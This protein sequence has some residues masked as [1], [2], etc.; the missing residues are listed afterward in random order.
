MARRRATPSPADELELPSAEELERLKLSPEVAW[1][2]VSRGIP[3]PDCP[4]AIKTPEPG[5]TCPGARFD[6]D[7]VDKVL[8]SFGLLRHTKGKWAGTP[9]QPDPWQVAYV[10]APVFG[11]V[12]FDE[13]VSRWV[14]VIRELYVDIPRKN[15]KSTTLGGIAI[16]MTAAD[17]EHGAEVI[18]AATTAEQAGFVFAPIKAMCD[19]APALKGHLK[20]YS[21]RIVHPRS[22]SYFQAISSV[23]DA[24]HGANIH[25]AV[26]D[27]LH[28]HKSA[29]LVETLETGTGSRDQPLVATITTADDGKPNTIYA[30]KR[31]RI[32]QLARQALTDPTTYGV[33]WAAAKD[34]DPFVEETWRKANPGFGISP[35]RSYLAKEA[36]KAKDSPA[37]LAKF[38][39][40]HLGI[41]TKQETKY[42]RLED[43]DASAGMVDELKLKG[44]ACHGGLD[45]ASVNDVTALC[46]DFPGENDQHELLWRFWLPEARIDDMNKRTAGAAAVWVR[47]GRLQLTPGNVIDLDYIFEQVKKDASVFDVRTIGYDRWGANSLVTKLGDEGIT[48]VPV[49]QGFAAM[50]APMKEWQRLV[51]TQRYTHGGDPVMRWMVD[52]LAVSMDPAGNV[53]PDKNRSAEKIDGVSA[54]VTALKEFMDAEVAEED[55]PDHIAFGI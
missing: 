42:L 17:G 11:W 40:L 19:K 30:R 45:L 2:L 8:K 28:V 3:L 35:T 29:D 12:R 44:R 49:G 53:K 51:L 18:A 16:Y 9:L 38:L 36:A 41:R 14:R 20:A 15:G 39:R 1:Y 31:T 6:P 32:E 24:Q 26:I 47:E 21:K 27:E 25:C 22:A 10:L 54:A 5:Q 33:I 46:W 50:S 37:E 48:C 4:P 23:A 52:N 55:E 34:D 7:R 13:D 43:W